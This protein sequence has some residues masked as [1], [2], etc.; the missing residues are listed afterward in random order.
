MNPTIKETSQCSEITATSQGPF[1]CSS[2]TTHMALSTEPEEPDP[3]LTSNDTGPES[4]QVGEPIKYHKPIYDRKWHCSASDMT[5][6]Q[7]G[8]YY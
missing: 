3:L 8:G 5:T 1:E 4:E 2:R 6:D 7:F